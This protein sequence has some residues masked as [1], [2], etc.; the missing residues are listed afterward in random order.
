VKVLFTID[1]PF[2]QKVHKIALCSVVVHSA[3]WDW[4]DVCRRQWQRRR[5]SDCHCADKHVQP[6]SSKLQLST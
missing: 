2:V 5:A 6:T 3:I 1:S 4:R